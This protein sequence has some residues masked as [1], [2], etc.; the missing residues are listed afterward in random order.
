MVE[1]RI[2]KTISFAGDSL[3]LMVLV[4]AVGIRLPT[5][6]RHYVIGA[7]RQSSLM[8]HQIPLL[9]LSRSTNLRSRHQ[10]DV[11]FEIFPAWLRRCGVGPSVDSTAN[12]ILS[13]G[14]AVDVPVWRR[15]VVLRTFDNLLQLVAPNIYGRL[16]VALLPETD[17]I[18]KHPSYRLA[19]AGLFGRRPHGDSLSCRKADRRTTLIAVVCQ[20]VVLR[21]LLSCAAASTSPPAF[22]VGHC[23]LFSERLCCCG[24]GVD[25]WLFSSPFCRF[26]LFSAVWQTI[27]LTVSATVTYALGKMGTTGD[28]VA[29]ALFTGRRRGGG[30]GKRNGVAV[31]RVRRGCAH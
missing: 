17:A 14:V 18:R 9:V 31:I 1:R 11:Q 21:V 23:R 29:R 26:G 16:G 12:E 15:A 25:N 4:G 3:F 22:A 13:C 28:A 19:A 8:V 10:T 6:V 2:G 7:N 27:E 5:S 30:Q 20:H 24:V